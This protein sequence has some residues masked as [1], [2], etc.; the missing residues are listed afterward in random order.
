[1]TNLFKRYPRLIIIDGMD[2]TGKTTTIK[3][4]CKFFNDVAVPYKVF[5]ADNPGVGISTDKID[6]ITKEYYNKF[7]SDIVFA[8]QSNQY[9]FIILD[10]SIKQPESSVFSSV[11]ETKTVSVSIIFANRALDPLSER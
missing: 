11:R 6:E 10:I 2:N 4:L 5:K 7:I 1:M 8:I 9:N 3:R